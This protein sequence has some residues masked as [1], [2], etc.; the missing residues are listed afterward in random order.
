LFDE[1]ISALAA[2]I[3][4]RATEIGDGDLASQDLLVEI[5]R[6]VEKQRWMLR[7]TTAR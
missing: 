6:G 2:R 1:R 4:Q 5:L 3:R 7:A